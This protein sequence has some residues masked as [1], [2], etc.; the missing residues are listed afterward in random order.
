MEKNACRNIYFIK[1]E[2]DVV[3]SLSPVQ[4]FVTPWTAAR[5]VSLSCAISWSLLKL[6]S[7]E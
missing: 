1:R 3:Q 4:L 6:M 2:I 5:Q 7:I